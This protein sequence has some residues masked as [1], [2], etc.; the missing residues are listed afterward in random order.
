MNDFDFDHLIDRQGTWSDKW[1]K[2][3]GTET[4]PMWVADTDF[5]SPDAVINAL[6][7]RVDHGVFGYTRTPETLN[8][9]F[10]ERMKRL[11]KWSITAEDLIWLPGLV[12]GLNLATRALSSHEQGVITAQPIY[13][14]F[15][16]APA[17]SARV[18]TTIPM[19]DRIIDFDALEQAIT[20]ETKL[21]LFC[22]PHNPGGGVY[23]R[24]ELERLAQIIINH[25]L[26]ICSDEIHCDLIL[27]PELN[28]TPIASLN[29]EIAS[30]TI[31][32]MAPSKTWNIAGLACSVAVIQNSEL[33]RRFNQVR[34]G[35]VPDVN[36]LGYTAAEAAY[37]YGDDWNRAQCEYLRVNR[38]LLQAEITNIPS[39]TMQRNEATYLAWIDATQ[40]GVEN[41]QRLFESHGVG[42]SDGQD[43]G[44]SGFVRL[45]FG[46]PRSRVEEAIRRIKL[47]VESL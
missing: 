43:F 9:V 32:L 39:L 1:S 38:D 11:Y 13:P 34:R 4:L 44:A 18:L 6:K 26:L 29:E 14:P 19:N 15:I 2:Y 31:T 5:R 23:R 47:A 30:R 46:C 25:D 20:A 37:S 35:I 33:R 27:E 7:N 24:H 41:P 28:H 40:L 3:A 22:N 36:L 8:R 12:C 45:N 17:H 16:S 10:T 21:L 42:L